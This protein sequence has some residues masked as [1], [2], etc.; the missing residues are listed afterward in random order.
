MTDK[1]QLQLVYEFSITEKEIEELNQHRS[2]LTLISE[3]NIFQNIFFFSTDIHRYFWEGA[4]SMAFSEKL[5][6]LLTCKS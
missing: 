1:L 5:S 2:Q 6:H 4:K 3:S